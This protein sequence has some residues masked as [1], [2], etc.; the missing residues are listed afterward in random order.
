MSEHR[1]ELAD[2]FRIHE[3]DFLARWGQVL[4]REQ[5]KAFADIRDCRT[6]ALAPSRG[7]NRSLARLSALLGLGLQSGARLVGSNSLA[8]V[9]SR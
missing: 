1:L 4:S 2:V 9:E 3:D 5:K 7:C 6:A 8:A